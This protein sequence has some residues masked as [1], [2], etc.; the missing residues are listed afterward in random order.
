MRLLSRCVGIVNQ[1]SILV[2]QVLGL[3]SIRG[4]FKL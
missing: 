2:C 1:D 4:G 3:H